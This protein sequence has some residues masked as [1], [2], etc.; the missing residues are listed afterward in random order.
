MPDVNQLDHS[1]VAGT[2][3]LIDSKAK[4]VDRRHYLNRGIVEIVVILCVLVLGKII[5][6]QVHST[7]A[8]PQIFFAMLISSGLGMF[9]SNWRPSD[10]T[11]CIR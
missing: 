2:I 11:Q 4:I 8:L 9:C 7:I 1:V 6:K 3:I 5:S 10:S